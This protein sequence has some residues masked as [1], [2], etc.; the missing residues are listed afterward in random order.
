MKN[1]VST[2]WGTYETSKKNGK[3]IKI[4]KW[5]KDPNPSDFGLGFLKSATDDLRINQP[6]IRKDWLKN[7][8]NRKNLR[9]L[10]EFVAVSWKEAI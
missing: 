8:D 4:N 5:S 6:Y 3:N 10:D 1:F 9:G 7:R 2:H